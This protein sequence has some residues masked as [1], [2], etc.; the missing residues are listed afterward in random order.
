[1]ETKE[2]KTE[3]ITL[4]VTPEV[5]KEFGIAK[6]NKI[7]Q[8][9]IIRRFVKT[10]V[11]WMESEL[12]EIDEATIKYKAKLI[13]IKDNFGLAQD[14]YIK[15]IENIYGIA[16]KT[17]SKFS[18]ITK[19]LDNNIDHVYEKL[20]QISTKMNYINTD[21]LEKLLNL[22]DRYNNMGNKERELIKLLLK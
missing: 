14:S 18:D 8:E 20:G 9:E 17:F 4:W 1:M 12:K 11:V 5:K 7:L 6:D 2:E 3:V 21:P 10:E 19:K 22:V 15:E 13:T 16:S